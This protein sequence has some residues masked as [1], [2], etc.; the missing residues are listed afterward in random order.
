VERQ[1]SI[2][3]FVKDKAFSEKVGFVPFPAV[4][5]G[6]GNSGTFQGGFGVGYAISSKTDQDAAYTALNF[7]LS[8]EQRKEITETGKISP[9]KS[10]ELDPAKTNPLVYDFANFISKE[11]K[12]FNGYYDQ[13]LDPKRSDKFLN[14]STKVAGDSNVDVLKELTEIK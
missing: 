7:I 5:G 11:A 14:F 1:Q 12:S 9:M 8:P 2:Q 6:N 4:E 13:Q 10:V 3:A